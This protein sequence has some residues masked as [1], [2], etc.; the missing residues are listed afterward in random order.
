M[1]VLASMMVK[2]LSK[3]QTSFF[4]KMGFNR[5]ASWKQEEIR[6]EQKLFL[7]GLKGRDNINFTE[8]N[9]EC[10]LFIGTRFRQ[11]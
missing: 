3:S 7:I 2:N 6:I 4:K 5:T 11:Y 1:W 10:E 8:R 9:E